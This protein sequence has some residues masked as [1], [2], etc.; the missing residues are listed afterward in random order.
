MTT[1]HN[2]P[3]DRLREE[4]TLDE[5]RARCESLDVATAKHL[6]NIV[7]AIENMLEPGDV[8]RWFGGK[9]IGALAIV[10]GGVVFKAIVTVMT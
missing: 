2:L 9:G 5:L 6:R 1:I 8:I 3:I 10:R 4:T 7:E